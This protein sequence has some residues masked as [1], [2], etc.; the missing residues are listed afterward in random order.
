MSISLTEEDKKI[1]E[2][3]ENIMGGVDIETLENMG[4]DQFGTFIG[5][6]DS[7]SLDTSSIG[8]AIIDGNDIRRLIS[9]ILLS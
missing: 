6:G 4:I 7:K 5:G 9:D 3:L 2:A 1:A 8:K